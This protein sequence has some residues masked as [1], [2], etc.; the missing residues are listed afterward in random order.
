MKLLMI[1]VGQSG[2][3][4]LAAA[5]RLGA[6]VHLVE[7]A[8]NAVE[9][10]DVVEQITECTG[11]PDETWAAAAHQAAE[12]GA[13]GVLAFSEPQV[14][15]AALVQDRLGCPGPSLRAATISRNKGL[16]RGVFAA[17][18]IGQPPWLLVDEVA[19]GRH[20]AQQRL[21]VVVKPLTL[22]G[23]AGVTGVETLAAFDDL[24]AQ[25][26][27]HGNFLVEQAL[28]GP[29]YSYEACVLAGTIWCSNV[30]AKE[31]SGPPDYVEISHR[32]GV[33][34]P[35]GVR[36][37]V[38]ALAHRVVDAAGIQTSLIHLEFRLEA[39]APM[40]MEVATRMPGD[41]IMDLLGLCYGFDW[42][43]LVVRAALGL[44]L[45]RVPA[46]P[47]RVAGTYLPSSKPGR[48]SAI[49]GLDII[50]AHPA[51]HGVEVYA[52]VGSMVRAPSSSADRV[53]Q[54]TV[55]APDE[56]A[57]EQ[58]MREVRATFHVDLDG[59]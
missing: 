8:T 10:A 25:R 38:D 58:A 42:Y 26:A 28:T 12:G 14:M 27:G 57:F 11:G 34:L 46:E 48:V 9:L 30:T 15:A 36:S 59:N 5:R 37:A 1:G 17:S 33:R 51:V 45:P 22:A 6:S 55:C 50:R 39:G 40:V 21:P 52:E 7:T 41:G 4:Y 20:W 19:K 43:E 23:S 13:D 54:I 16:Q 35:A 18:G 31:T 2:R 29:E 3:P 49:H 32:A 56:S 47:L 24:A 53:A 44:E